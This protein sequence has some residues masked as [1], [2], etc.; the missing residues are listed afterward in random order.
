MVVLG[1]EKGLRRRGCRKGVRAGV[2]KGLELGKVGPEVGGAV[3]SA[4]PAWEGPGPVGRGAGHGEE[5]VRTRTDAGFSSFTEAQLTGQTV[6][7]R[8]TA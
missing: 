1:A 8:R 6:S 2:H 3:N 4:S 5:W 7:L